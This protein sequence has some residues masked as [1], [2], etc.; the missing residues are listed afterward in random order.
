MFFQ[1]MPNLRH[2]RA[3]SLT[4]RHGSVHRAA[5]E[6]CLSQPAVTQAITK[7]ETEYGASFFERSKTGMSVSDFGRIFITRVDRALDIL[8][9]AAAP[10]S[11][12]KSFH[13]PI[14][15]V[16]EVVFADEGA[17]QAALPILTSWPVGD[18]KLATYQVE[19]HDFI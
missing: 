11:K 7:L 8:S 14:A 6:I 19:A 5:A 9:Q 4:A 1:F 16:V 18:R 10:N 13:V 2:L 15:G 3:L 12:I 17:M